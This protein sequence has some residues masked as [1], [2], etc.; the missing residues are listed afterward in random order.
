MSPWS[1]GRLVEALQ[2]KGFHTI[3]IQEGGDLALARG[4]TIVTLPLGIGDDIPDRV[5]RHNLRQSGIDLDE[6]RHMM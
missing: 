3:S 5:V 4:P 1:L 6:L 2:G